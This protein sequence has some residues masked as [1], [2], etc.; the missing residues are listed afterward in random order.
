MGLAGLRDAA[1]PE[2]NKDSVLINL[3]RSISS[4]RYRHPPRGHHDQQPTEPAP[5]ANRFTQPI[6]PA[7]SAPKHRFAAHQQRHPV[8]KYVLQRSFARRTQTR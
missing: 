8:G 3:P 5:A 4:T 2:P 7:N 6:T 1:T